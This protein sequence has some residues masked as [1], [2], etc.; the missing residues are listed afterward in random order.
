MK[1]GGGAS[2]GS[3]SKLAEKPEALTA[4]QSG[5]QAG[6]VALE[7]KEGCVQ[8]AADIIGSKWTA[9]ILRDL[10]AC[11]QHFCTL[12]KS[13]GK[14]NPRT[15]SQRLDELEARGIVVKEAGSRPAYTL[16]QKGEDLIP[17]LKHMADWGNKYSTK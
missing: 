3:T 7:P 4:A 17:V 13:V 1:Y 5:S 8:A 10:A 16:T 2:Q 12:E 9:L 15:L 11:P 6:Q 14:I